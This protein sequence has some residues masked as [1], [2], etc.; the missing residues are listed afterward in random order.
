M[1]ER[2]LNLNSV[3]NARELG[4][5]P[6]SGGRMVRKGLLIRAG[7]LSDLSPED[8]I[9]LSQQWKL[10]EIIDLRN[11]AEIAEHPNQPIP[12]VTTHVVPIFPNGEVGVTREDHG[13]DMIDLCIC[14]AGKYRNGGAR[15][16]L[17][18]LYPK[19]VCDESCLKGIRHFF[20]ILLEHRDGAVLWHCTSG[21]D[22]TGVTAALLLLA[23]GASWET[24]LEDYLLTNIQTRQQREALCQGMADR[25]VAPELIEEIRTI[26]SVDPV[27]LETCRRLIEEQYGSV[28][29]F[30]DQALGLTEEKRIRLQRK[31]TCQA[32][33]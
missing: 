15:R 31:Y 6:L 19:M 32:T 8:R 20:E 16:L 5:I 21:K 27:Y 17:E 26:E 24:V 3:K 22:R 7:R 10:T 14:V 33:L 18:G 23:L 12:G 28:D 29:R 2:Y 1:S 25:N 11:S 30:F 13:M 4:G 9:A